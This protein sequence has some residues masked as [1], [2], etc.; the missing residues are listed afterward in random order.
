MKICTL[1]F[2]FRNGKIILAKKRKKLVLVS[3]MVTVEK[4]KRG[5]IN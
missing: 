1:G 5:K 2:L 4:W 3:G